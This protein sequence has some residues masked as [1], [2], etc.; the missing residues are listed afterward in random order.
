MT[1]GSSDTVSTVNVTFD[2][3]TPFIELLHGYP[4]ER[5]EAERDR[6]RAEVA[7][8]NTA[9]QLLDLAITMR[10]AE[11]PRSSARATA[12]VDGGSPTTRPR[13]LRAS[14]LAV[15]SDGA[16]GTEWT[17]T[18]IHQ[19]LDGRGWS[20]K[21]SAARSQI[22]NRLRDLVSTGQVEKVGSGRYT[23]AM[24][25]EESDATGLFAPADSKEG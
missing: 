20:P 23:L 14:V 2:T 21:G 16:P 4:L 25:T 10:A 3:N 11:T 18:A 17:P 15:M 5:L 9:M 12:T 8:L 13:T 6:V 19:A 24:R 7:R 22:S 1:T